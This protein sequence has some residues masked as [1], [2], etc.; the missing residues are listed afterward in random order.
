M[1]IKTICIVLG[2]LLAVWPLAA[3]IPLGT[4]RQ[5]LPYVNNFRSVAAT[6]EMIYV[7][8]EQSIMYMDKSDMTTHAWSKVE[9]LSDM[10]IASIACNKASNTLI[11]A[12]NNGNVDIIKD[13]KLLNLPDIKN[14][15]ITG[16]K[17]IYS[18]LTTPEKAYLSTAFGVIV[19]NLDNGTVQDTWYTAYKGGYLN[20]YGIEIVDNLMYMITER[21]IYT[22]AENAVDVADFASWQLVTGTETMNVNRMTIFDN[23]LFF[24]TQYLHSPDSLYV[25]ENGTPHYLDSNMQLDQI[26]GLKANDKRLAIA[27]DRDIFFYNKNLDLEL[28]A[29]WRTGLWIDQ[30]NNLLFEGDTVWIADGYNG[31]VLYHYPDDY[32]KHYHAGGPFTYMTSAI[33]AV[34]GKVAVV[35]GARE[36][37]HLSWIHPSLSVFGNGEWRFVERSFYDFGM[38]WDINNVAIN[39]RNENEIWCTSWGCGLYKIEND[40]VTARYDS[41]NSP[42]VGNPYPLVSGIRFDRNNNLWITTS[43]TFYPLHVLKS[44]GTWKS[45]SLMPAANVSSLTDKKPEH[46]LVDSRGYKWITFSRPFEGLVVAFDDNGT[47]DNPSDDRIARVEV[48]YNSSDAEPASRVITCIAE[49]KDGSIWLGTTTGIKVFY[50]PENVFTKNGVYYAQYIKFFQNGYVEL[51]LKN[52]K[53]TA[54]AVDGA[55]RKWIGTAGAGLFLVSENGTES[56]LH[57]T[58]ENSP[59]FSNSI[60]SLAIDHSNGE[61]FI[62][63][64]NGLLSYRGD[65]TWGNETYDECKVFP[66]PVREGYTGPV[67][68]SGLID[69]S[70]CKITD[71]EGKLVWQGYANGGELIWNC[72]DFYGNRP[73]TGVYYVMASNP[74]GKE[75][76][77]AKFLFIH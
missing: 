76:K 37:M 35:P 8:T 50:Y 19:I 29:N 66:N 58:E 77:V 41:S 49:D 55:N 28:Q 52:E 15:Q 43:N 3:Q 6:K 16:S 39:P 56:L 4:F 23:R 12:Y 24:S 31:L 10:G 27:T 5:H 18:L 51:L 1:R 14:K 74:V 30:V 47:I 72:Q 62:G 65:A 42:L 70:F 21:G 25:Y 11:I 61:V 32:S 73:A 33:D 45:F 13:D 38:A 69:K 20:V 34:N 71:A 53:I 67:A 57:F 68:V 22:H 7:A 75:K 46:V 26:R 40:Q 60:T 64:I 59:L 63:T 36:E 17:R 9:G 48:N 44:D 2:E 54:I